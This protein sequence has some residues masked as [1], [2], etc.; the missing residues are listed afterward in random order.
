MQG[1]GR[2]LTILP[3]YP[4]APN[5]ACTNE[6]APRGESPDGHTAEIPHGHTAETPDSH[7]VVAD[8]G[9]HGITVVGMCCVEG[10]MTSIPGE[11]V[12][13]P[14]RKQVRA[15]VTYLCRGT[16]EERTGQ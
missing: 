7:P 14:P 8:E 4:L 3:W 1:L 13:G 5:L 10:L 15:L 6:A 16:S 12:V 2:L 11:V 9:S